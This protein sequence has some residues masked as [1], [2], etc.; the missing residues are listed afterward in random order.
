VAY[1]NGFS[2]VFAL[3]NLGSP[4]AKSYTA[5]VWIFNEVDKEMAD[6]SKHETA[7]SYL[8]ANCQSN[9]QQW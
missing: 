9:G 6:S 5:D 8:S 2:G 4:P 1:H 3:D 7:W